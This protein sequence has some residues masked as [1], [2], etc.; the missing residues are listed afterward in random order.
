MCVQLCTLEFYRMVGGRRDL[1]A[2]ALEPLF[3][4]SLVMF[5]FS[6][7]NGNWKL[8]V[9]TNA[10][11]CGLASTRAPPVLLDL[12]PSLWLFCHNSGKC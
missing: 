3:V 8:E 7:R 1:Q 12:S 11:G 5:L 4:L 6:K 9:F 2:G 10:T